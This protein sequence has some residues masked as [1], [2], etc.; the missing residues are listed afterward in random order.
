MQIQGSL[1]LFYQQD[2][3]ILHVFGLWIDL[4]EMDGGMNGERERVSPFADGASDL[5]LGPVMIALQRAAA[6]IVAVWHRFKVN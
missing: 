3:C 6:A 4:H 2:V 1:W 5:R